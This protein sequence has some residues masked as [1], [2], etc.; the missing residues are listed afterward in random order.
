MADHA[1]VLARRFPSR[2]AALGAL[3][4]ALTDTGGPYRARLITMG[5][6]AAILPVSLLVGT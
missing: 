6:G 5:L 1:G 3:H 2:P 4:T